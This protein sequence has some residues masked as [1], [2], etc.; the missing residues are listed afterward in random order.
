MREEHFP[1]S[2]CESVF[3]LTPG[4]AG[5][6]WTVHCSPLLL[7]WSSKRVWNGGSGHQCLQLDE[8]GMSW[9]FQMYLPCVA[10]GSVVAAPGEMYILLFIY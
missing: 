3:L 2:C 5:A 8:E 9:C 7:L 10:V 4:S 6:D 1:L